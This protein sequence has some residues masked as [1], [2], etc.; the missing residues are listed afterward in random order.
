MPPPP[1]APLEIVTV[2]SKAHALRQRQYS[3]LILGRALDHL[4]RT[5]ERLDPEELAERER[6]SAPAPTPGCAAAVVAALKRLTASSRAQTSD[7]ATTQTATGVTRLF[8]MR[9]GA[10]EKLE[11]AIR[12]T[13]A[14]QDELATTAAESRAK[15]KA[16]HQAGKKHEALL[17]LRRAKKLEQQGDQAAMAELAL[18]QQLSA[19]EGA[20]LNSEVASALKSSVK[21]SKKKLRGL[22]SKT[23]DAVE[24]TAA[25]LDD[26]RDVTDTMSGLQTDNYDEDE[27]QAE[28]EAML[29]AA[30]PKAAAAAQPSH[31]LEPSQLPA[32]PRGGVSSVPSA[33]LEMVGSV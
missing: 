13:Q 6:A 10:V 9:K 4:D 21:R 23:E 28:L 3:L 2:E 26:V 7:A 5:G 11:A 18:E 32:A 1:P 12:L 8:G 27:L 29:A 16:A 20:S 33:G 14:R 30:P 22:L 17:A 15:A 31:A 25:L 24:D 19:M